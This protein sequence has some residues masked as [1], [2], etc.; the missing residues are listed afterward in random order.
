MKKI[1]ITS[2]LTILSISLLFAENE[3]QMKTTPA[4]QPL[5][6]VYVGVD[7]SYGGSISSTQH[8]VPDYEIRMF[9]GYR[10]LPQFKAAI[11]FGGANCYRSGIT[12]VPVFIQLRS[13]FLAKAKVTPFIAIDAGYNFQLDVPKSWDKLKI[14]KEVFKEKLEGLTVDEFLE[15]YYP[16]DKDAGMSYLTAFSNGKHEYTEIQNGYF[17]K[18]GW[19]SSLTIGSSIKLK[20]I[21]L[22]LSLVAGFSQFSIGKEYRTNNNQFLDFKTTD[23]LPN[24][25]EVYIQSMNQ[26]YKSIVPDFRIKIGIS[27]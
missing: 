19:F 20:D 2:I 16:E 6:N 17:S 23:K 25:N 15:K 14:N 13:D 10:F 9:A 26:K 5:T 21:N 27:F 8:F 24:G 3:K 7:L 18:N 22:D 11:G 1:I 4:V 12:V